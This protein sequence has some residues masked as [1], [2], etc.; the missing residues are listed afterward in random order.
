MYS[1]IC[2]AVLPLAF[3]SRDCCCCL[4]GSEDLNKESRPL[5]DLL[6]IMS[7]CFYPFSFMRKT[8]T[9]KILSLE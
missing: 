2:L 7:E 4:S 8:L 1:L 6:K 9:K 5:N 3:G